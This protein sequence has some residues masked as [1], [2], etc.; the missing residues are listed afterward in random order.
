S[1]PFMTVDRCRLVEDPSSR[2]LR[3]L[4]LLRRKWHRG[5][6]SYGCIG[7]CRLSS[8]SELPDVSYRHD[9][10]AVLARLTFAKDVKNCLGLDVVLFRRHGRGI[11]GIRRRRSVDGD[12]ARLAVE[13]GRTAAAPNAP[14]IER[15]TGDFFAQAN[16][17]LGFAFDVLQ[18][19]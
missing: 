13:A 11:V 7:R 9:R 19:A 10:A 3:R 12:R 14:A 1:K 6:E 16:K 4:D 15:D 5:F 2:G 8:D 17:R 18:I